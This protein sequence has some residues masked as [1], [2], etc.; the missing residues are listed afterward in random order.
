MRPMGFAGNGAAS[1]LQRRPNGTD[2]ILDV[3][4]PFH[5]GRAPFIFL[6]LMKRAGVSLVRTKVSLED[7]ETM[8][9]FRSMGLRTGRY[10]E[11]KSH[12]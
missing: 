9:F 11:L 5:P 10:I 4:G 12:I 8:S 2:I 6:G 3:K 1:L 7:A